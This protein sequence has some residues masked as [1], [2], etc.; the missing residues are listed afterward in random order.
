[1]YKM[2]W[3]ID[4]ISSD[5]HNLRYRIT[6]YCREKWLEKIQRAIKN[7]AGVWTTLLKLKSFAGYLEVVFS[8]HCLGVNFFPGHEFLPGQEMLFMGMICSWGCHFVDKCEI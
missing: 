7:S 3:A 5:L 4:N 6:C 8:L 2:I 1:V